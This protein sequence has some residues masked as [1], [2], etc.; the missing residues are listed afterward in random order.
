MKGTR[1]KKVVQAQQRECWR[2]RTLVAA[3][4]ALSFSASFSQTRGT[5]R[6]MVGLTALVRCT[7]DPSLMS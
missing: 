3:P 2:G 1:K 7:T 4:M 6:N 5:P